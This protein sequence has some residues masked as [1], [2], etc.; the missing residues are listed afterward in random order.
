MVYLDYAA[1]TPISDS[2]LRVFT[3][4]S[5]RFYGNASSLHDAGSHAKEML[6]ACRRQFAQFVNG[7]SKG[8]YFTSG[9]SESNHLAL[10]SLIRAHSVKGK[11]LITT[12]T[13][14]PSVTNTFLLLENEGY[15]VTWL[16]VD[17]T[18]MIR[19]KD[20]EEAITEETILVSIGH[21]NS[22]IGTIQPLAQIGNIVKEKGILFH[23]D[24]V[25][26]FGKVPINVKELGLDSLSISSHKLYGPKGV[27]ACYI[28]PHIRWE[29][30]I[31]GTSHE[32]G[33][34]QGTVNVPGIA[35]F[36]VAAEEMVNNIDRNNN[37]FLSLRKQL[38]SEL[39]EENW[40][41]YEGHPTHS[42][43]S[44]IGLRVKGIE[45]QYMMLELNGKGYAISTGSACSTGKQAPSKTMISIGRSPDEARELIRISLGVTTTTD[46]IK[47]FISD[48]K[49]ILS[50]MKSVKT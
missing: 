19:I 3:E 44:I 22:E 14:H 16:P 20:L 18:G 1:S 37:H 6:E 9:G 25:Q 43:P 32:S 34:R 23:S 10:Q 38:L 49:I 42:L 2:A 28:S 36:T 13:E 17:S 5:K 39:V 26:T 48:I 47:G 15:H 33:F 29:P 30:S 35:A 50:I 45:G 4:S 41:V 12:S 31:P 21:A 11:H 27:G 46:E 40:V 7:E 24:C 8:I